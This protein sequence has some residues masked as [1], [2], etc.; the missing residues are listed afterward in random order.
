MLS[1][2]MVN[3]DSGQTKVKQVWDPRFDKM[4]VQS[5]AVSRTKSGGAI[6]LSP[7][8]PDSSEARPTSS[9]IEEVMEV[10][11]RWSAKRGPK[12]KKDRDVQYFPVVDELLNSKGETQ[13]AVV[14]DLAGVAPSCANEILVPSSTQSNTSSSVE[15]VS[16][17]EWPSSTPCVAP[18]SARVSSS[19]PPSSGNAAIAV[20]GRNVDAAEFIPGFS[21]GSSA[22]LSAMSTGKNSLYMKGTI[23]GGAVKFLIDTGAENSV[24]SL[25]VLSKLSKEVRSKFQDTVSVLQLAD[26]KELYAKGPVLCEIEVNGR[27]VLDVVYAAPVKDEAILGLATL[28]MLDCDITVAGEKLSTGKRAAFRQL[29]TPCVRRVVATGGVVVPPRLQAVV[30]VKIEGGGNREVMVGPRKATRASRI[31][32]AR[33]LVKPINANCTIPVLN[34][35]DSPYAIKRGDYLGNAET[36]EVLEEKVP[37]RK[38]FVEHLPEHL[39]KIFE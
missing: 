31:G 14:V 7:I 1:E 8:L 4:S 32:V 33:T 22:K 36:V 39:V 10:V 24:V 30:E 26:G 37:V 17:V 38:V 23:E 15:N 12:K 19:V 27:R 20:P 16:N 25:K 21:V 18:S 29:S 34:T 5:G 3:E 11:E 35:E 2:V 28:M 9:G 6:S 13:K